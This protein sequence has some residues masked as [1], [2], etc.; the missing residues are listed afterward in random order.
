MVAEVMSAYLR[1][2]LDDVF[3]DDVCAI[4]FALGIDKFL[5]FGIHARH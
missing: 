2:R 1:E 5:S 3:F 4:L